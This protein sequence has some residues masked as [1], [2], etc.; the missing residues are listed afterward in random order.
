MQRSNK[1]IRTHW[2]TIALVSGLI[3]LLGYFV[4]PAFSVLR[5]PQSEVFGQAWQTAKDNFYDSKFNGVD[6]QAMRQKYQPLAD[7]ARS[8]EGLSDVINQMLAELK[9]SHTRFYTQDE[10]A[11]YQLSGIF[12][13]S[14]QNRLKPFLPN[15]KL[16]YT[17]IGIF[18]REANSKTFIR[19]ILDNSP[20]AKA[21]LKVGD[22]V[23][24]VNNQPFRPIQSF[25]NKAG[26]AVQMQI[27]RTANPASVQTIAVTPQNL[28]PAGC[29]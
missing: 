16:E 3:V 24:S 12:K 11:Y 1:I 27:Q 22:Q 23:L 7:K 6:W 15:G 19:A 17:D 4:S 14:I 20:A 9:T 28:T 13:S 26:Q 8:R 21:G 29:F 18:T 25:E 2:S 10:P 5:S